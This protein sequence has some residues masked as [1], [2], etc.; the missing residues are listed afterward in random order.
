MAGQ[1]QN[2]PKICATAKETDLEDSV[3]F[4]DQVCLGCT[5]RAAQVNNRTVM[6]NQKLYSKLISTSTDVKTEEK[7]PKDITAGSQ[8]MEGHGQKVC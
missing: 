4:T 8:H 5:Q 2:M 6:E 3:S 1:T 7:N